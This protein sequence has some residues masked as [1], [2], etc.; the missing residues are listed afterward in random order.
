MDIFPSTASFFLMYSTHTADNA[1]MAAARQISWIS[2]NRSS[3]PHIFDIS[4]IMPFIYL[5]SR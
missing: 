4:S 5:S 3:R 2:T 1:S